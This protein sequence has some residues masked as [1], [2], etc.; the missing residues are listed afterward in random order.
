MSDVSAKPPGKSVCVEVTLVR[1]PSNVR[2]LR[3]SFVDITER[4][5]AADRTSA[6]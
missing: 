4:N 5:R 3:A 2:L 6:A 1:L